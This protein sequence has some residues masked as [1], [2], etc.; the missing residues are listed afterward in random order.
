M[1]QCGKGGN[2]DEEH[3]RNINR[4]LMMKKKDKDTSENVPWQ[5]LILKHQPQ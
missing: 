3:H 2:K 4:R 5:Y 1:R